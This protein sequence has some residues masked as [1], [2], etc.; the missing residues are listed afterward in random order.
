M[1]PKVRSSLRSL[2]IESAAYAVLVTLYFF[3]V[4]HFLGGWLNHLFQDERKLYAFVAL[5]LIVGQG[6]LLE[7]LTRLLLS[8]I[9]RAEDK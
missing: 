7:V 2:L 3:L 1:N 9:T 5:G 8:F 4:L 6:L